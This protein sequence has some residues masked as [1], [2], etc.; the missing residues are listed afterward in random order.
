M[1]K[2]C[3]IGANSLTGEKILGILESRNVWNAEQK[4]CEGI[5]HPDSQIVAGEA[6]AG[7]VEKCI[8]DFKDCIVLGRTRIDAWAA[9]MD[10]ER[11]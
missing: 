5:N 8:E 4:L 11:E 9:Q 6:I 2:T 3:C 1:G 7:R 10:A